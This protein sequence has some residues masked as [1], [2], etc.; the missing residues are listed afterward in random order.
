MDVILIHGMGRTPVSMLR[1][2]HHLRRA[3]HHPMLFGYSPT[4]ESLQGATG[5]LVRLIERRVETAPYALVGHSLGTVIIRSAL[6]QLENRMPAAC[7]FLS[8]PMVA[9]RAAKFFSRFW[10][11]K[12]L[13]GEMGQLLADDAFM[14]R[15][16][17]P[18]AFTRIYVG[19]GGPRTR[20]YPFGMEA[21]DLILSVAEATGRFKALSV[22]V[23][24]LHT[25]IMHSPQVYDDI[26]R[27]LAALVDTSSTPR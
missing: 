12:V 11:Y 21:N 1:L 3:G 25:F 6:G 14:Q 27:S 5:R 15:L 18:P 24:A 16:P 7:F 4:F 8:P 9:C 19:T 17:M 22:E 26:I 10:L 23:P 20:W 13:A 2:R